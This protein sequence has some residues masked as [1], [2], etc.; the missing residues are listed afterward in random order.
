MGFAAGGGV[1]PA[2]YRPELWRPRPYEG[3]RHNL[4]ARWSPLVFDSAVEIDFEPTDLVTNHDARLW[5]YPEQSGPAVNAPSLSGTTAPNVAQ[6]AGAGQ[7]VHVSPGKWYA[8][9]V[10][11]SPLAFVTATLYLHDLRYVAT[12]LNPGPLVWGAWTFDVAGAVTATLVAANF[13]RRGLAL[14]NEGAQ[15]AT[16]VFSAS[17]AT[18]VTA[19]RGFVLAGGQRDVWT[20]PDMSRQY[21]RIIRNTVDVNVAYSEAT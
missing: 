14:R 4:P 9:V 18:V 6:S 13:R 3:K 5:I 20:G 15:A 2:I 17:A 21:V 10:A 7:S 8:A 16:Y 11:G 1:A 19:G 12:E